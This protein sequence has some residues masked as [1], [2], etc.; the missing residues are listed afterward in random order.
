MASTSSVADR[1]LPD[2]VGVARVLR[3][4]GVRGEVKVEIHSDVPGRFDRGSELIVRHDGRPQTRSRVASFRW[5][6][7][8]G[9]LRFEGFDD[10]DAA[11]TLRGAWL[12]V[13]RAAVPPA[14]SGAFYHFELAGCLCVDHEAGELGV[15]RDV[16]E[17][18]GGVLL[19]LV[20][21][22]REILV[23]FVNAFLD[24]VDIESRRIDVR[25]PPG[26]IETCVSK[27]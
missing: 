15:V 13:D 17:D 9:L 22:E 6:G 8:I 1:S 18:G 23:P 12:E 11:N 19:R 14:E 2:T 16:L 5:Q 4:H 27:S 7:D 21:G 10:R 24:S 25:L 20:D 3:P 26:L